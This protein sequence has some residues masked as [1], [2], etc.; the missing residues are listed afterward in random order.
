[1]VDKQKQS[2]NVY[3]L[4]ETTET[5]LTALAKEASGESAEHGIPDPQPEPAPECVCNSKCEKGEVNEKCAVCA[6]DLT[7]CTGK[8]APEPEPQP[9]KPDEKPKEKSGGASSLILILLVVAVG[10]GA[11][12]YLKIYKPKHD[13]DDADDLDDFTF[14]EAPT[15]TPEDEEVIVLSG[16]DADTGEDGG[17]ETI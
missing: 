6:A 1:M 11:A 4:S 8:A 3:L 12:Y 10:G 13:L 2:E 14:E 9:E 7:A 16:D 17:D 15:E 5:E